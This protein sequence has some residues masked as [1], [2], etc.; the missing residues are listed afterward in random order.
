MLLR[1]VYIFK[2]ITIKNVDGEVSRFN[3]EFFS[4]FYINLQRGVTFNNTILSKRSLDFK[5][6]FQSE[7][8]N[9][10]EIS[11]TTK[12]LSN[13]GLADFLNLISEQYMPDSILSFGYAPGCLNLDQF[14]I[15]SCVY[16]KKT[17][18]SAMLINGNH[19][20]AVKVYS[21]NFGTDIHPFYRP[22][23]E[24]ADSLKQSFDLN[25]DKMYL[26]QILDIYS[27]VFETIP[28]WLICIK[29]LNVE[30]QPDFTTCGFY[31]I[32][33]CILFSFNI[34]PTTVSYG[35]DNLRKFCSDARNN[36]FFF[37]GS[38]FKKIR[39]KGVYYC[40]LVNIRS[41][42]EFK[43]IT[44]TKAAL[45]KNLEPQNTKFG[46]TSKIESIPCNNSH[47]KNIATSNNTLKSQT[48]QNSEF[49]CNRF[50]VGNYNS[51][52]GNNETL[53]QRPKFQSTSITDKI[54]TSNDNSKS[55]KTVSSRPR[56]PIILNLMLRK[57]IRSI[58]LTENIILQISLK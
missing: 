13:F 51:I 45:N 56:I 17:I 11:D 16:D 43:H 44:S 53:N 32:F 34:C 54:G 8:L 14:K 21:E 12:M 3:F 15:K 24:I 22:V 26:K 18:V 27:D 41:F 6:K 31:S 52:L 42:T 9:G 29:F 55:Q 37:N 2:L 30:Q 33:N 23:I 35:R 36:G 40:N 28:Q 46:N 38:N 57:T 25:R 50:I 7:T 1:S 49:D 4:F 58:K 10:V 47:K 19:F 20:V 48:N 39:S 5:F